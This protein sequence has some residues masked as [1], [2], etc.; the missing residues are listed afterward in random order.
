[1]GIFA[2]TILNNNTV[3]TTTPNIGSK[4]NTTYPSGFYKSTDT[5]TGVPSYY[6]RGKVDNNYVSFAGKTWRIVRINEDYTV[7]LIMQ[8]GINSNKAYKF[9][10]TQSDFSY[11]YY[12]NTNVANGAKYI[13]DDWY[14][15]NIASNSEYASKVVVGK[16]FC[17]QAKFKYTA[18]ATSGNASMYLYNATD[19]PSDYLTFKCS[20]DG[21]GKGL[22]DSNIGLLTVEEAIY[23]GGVP[24]TS[25]TSSYLYLNNG[26]ATQLMSGSG[27]NSAA[28]RWIIASN[29]SVQ[30]ANATSTSTLR[31]VINIASGVTTTGTGTKSDPYVIT[32]KEVSYTYPATKVET[33]YDAIKKYDTKTTSGTYQYSFTN[34]GYYYYCCSCNPT[35]NESVCPGASS[36]NNNIAGKACSCTTQ[37]STYKYVCN[38]D[39]DTLNSNNTCTHTEYTCS[40]GGVLNGTTCEK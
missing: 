21:N 6:F 1:M 16:Y 2:Q 3:V 25:A 40:D 9:N 34:S 22:V 37:L 14:N 20:T 26:S 36:Q 35:H 30:D 5:N 8:T 27:Y 13:L 32:G 29:G 7:R 33:T 11:M 19:L 39:T 38:R 10:T 17:E 4:I 31:P 15:T 23:A 12:T 18:K 28:K 24:G